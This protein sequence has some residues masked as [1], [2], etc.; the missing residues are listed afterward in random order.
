M[1]GNPLVSLLPVSIPL[2]ESLQLL[3]LKTFPQN[4]D[5]GPADVQLTGSSRCEGGTA[6]LQ[7]IG[8]LAQFQLQIYLAWRNS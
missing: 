6:N 8:M 2:T 4:F 7:L 3:R 5:Q 1:T